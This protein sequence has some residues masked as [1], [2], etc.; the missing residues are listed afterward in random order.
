M[1]ITT[2]AS[3]QLTPSDDDRDVA[4]ARV[5]EFAAFDTCSIEDLEHEVAMRDAAVDF[6]AVLQAHVPAGPWREVAWEK[7]EHTFLIASRAL[8]AA[9]E[10]DEPES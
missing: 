10:P 2:H 7:L 9:A 3:T 8:A 5:A 4:L 6:G 1:T